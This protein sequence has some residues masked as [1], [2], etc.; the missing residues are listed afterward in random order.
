MS[1]FATL[2]TAVGVVLASVSGLVC[3]LGPHP[4][5]TYLAFLPDSPMILNHPEVA[6]AI[7][8]FLVLLGLLSTAPSHT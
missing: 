2:I 8:G 6:F 7:G 5:Y 1:L 4:S 3:Y